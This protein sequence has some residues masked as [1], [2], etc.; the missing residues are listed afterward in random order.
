MDWNVSVIKH[1]FVIID[2]KSTLPDSDNL[3]KSARSDK[4][5]EVFRQAVVYLKKSESF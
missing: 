2:S 4:D 1:P 5:T 3:Q